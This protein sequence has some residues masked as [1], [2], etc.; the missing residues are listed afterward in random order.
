MSSHSSF[1][2]CVGHV[3]HRVVICNGV[4]GLVVG[5]FGAK[6]GEFSLLVGNAGDIVGREPAALGSQQPVPP[7]GRLLCQH[8]ENIIVAK[9]EGGGVLSLIVIES[10]TEKALVFFLL[11]LIVT[12]THSSNVEKLNHYLLTI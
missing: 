6:E 7:P 8:L 2:A 12:N 5:D 9:G 4:V 10:P 3:E 11:G 1:S